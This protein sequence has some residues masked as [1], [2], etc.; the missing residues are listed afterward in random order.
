MTSPGL[1]PT[2][3]EAALAREPVLLDRLLDPSMHEAEYPLATDTEEAS[4][5]AQACTVG[6]KRGRERLP[7]DAAS[8]A[9]ASKHAGEMSQRRL[10]APA[11]CDLVP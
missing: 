8:V 9:E 1:L 4:Y 3:L 10:A 5:F 2:A 6:D 11:R 7:E